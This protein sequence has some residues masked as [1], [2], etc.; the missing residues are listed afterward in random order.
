MAGISHPLH[1]HGAGY[2]PAPQKYISPPAVGVANEP[3]RAALEQFT[4]RNP[5]QEGA[6][7]RNRAGGGTR[8]EPR[9]APAPGFPL[10]RV[11]VRP[12][13]T[14]PRLF[15]RYLFACGAAPPAEQA[16]AG[17]GCQE[18]TGGRAGRCQ[19]RAS[20]AVAPRPL[21][22]QHHLARAG[23]GERKDVFPGKSRCYSL[24]FD[25]SSFAPE[26]ERQATHVESEN[27]QGDG[28]YVTRTTNAWS[29]RTFTS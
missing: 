3:V 27:K 24:Y 1:P 10:V 7:E 14:G 8:P 18:L 21:C 23:S 15:L 19:G 12:P 17:A 9:P 5:A 22:L 25:M 16:G 28:V 26:G 11:P 6:A 2:H 13:G 20:W 4:P 29:S